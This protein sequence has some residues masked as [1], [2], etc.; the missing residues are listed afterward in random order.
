VDVITSP[1]RVVTVVVKVTIS[2]LVGMVVVRVAV[3]MG[4]QTVAILTERPN[5]TVIRLSRGLS[6]RLIGESR[7]TGR[8]SRM[9]QELARNCRRVLL[10]LREGCERRRLLGS[11]FERAWICI[12]LASNQTGIQATLLQG[13]LLKAMVDGGN[14][15]WHESTDRTHRS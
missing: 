10:A 5:Q 13:Q 14:S 6:K 4:V 9:K 1:G 3:A 7:G 8:T 11:T 15:P 12:F 2:V